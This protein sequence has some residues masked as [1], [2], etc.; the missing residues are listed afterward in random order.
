M[1]VKLNQLNL[2]V[3]EGAHK[4]DVKA[5]FK[6]INE[7]SQENQLMNQNRDKNFK[8]NLSQKKNK[9]QLKMQTID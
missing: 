6:S 7:I 4:Y 1:K 9:F 5:Y 3:Y 8:V 2:D